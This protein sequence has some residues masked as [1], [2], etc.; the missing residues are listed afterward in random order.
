MQ[1][2]RCGGVLEAVR[3]ARLGYPVRL[4]HA[5]FLKQYKCLMESSFHTRANAQ[6][7]E[8]ETDVMRKLCREFLESLGLTAD[9]FQVGLTKTFFR[10]HAFEQLESRRNA[11]LKDAAIKLQAQVCTS[12]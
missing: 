6:L 12:Q 8:P 9:D 11:S 4:I 1:Q 5:A 2:L 10:K 3:V 7:K